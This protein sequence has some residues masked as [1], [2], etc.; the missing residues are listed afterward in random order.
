MAI[1][2]L[3]THMFLHPS[4]LCFQGAMS[5]STSKVNSIKVKL[6]KQITHQ[7]SMYCVLCLT[8]CILALSHIITI[9][10]PRSIHIFILYFLE[11]RSS[12]QKKLVHHQ[13]FYFLPRVIHTERVLGGHFS[14]VG[15]EEKFPLV[16]KK[17][18]VS[19]EKNFRL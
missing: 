11:I 18:S 16:V 3:P 9:L 13:T 8:S 14:S 12:T 7:S 1:H 19:G 10:A 6:F 4:A 2:A 17:I 15:G 5:N